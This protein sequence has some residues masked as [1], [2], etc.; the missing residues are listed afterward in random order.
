MNAQMPSP[1]IT[2]RHI[3][4]TTALRDHIETKLASISLDFPRIMDAHVILDA[5]KHRRSCEIVLHC[6]A[7][8]RFQVSHASDDMYTSIDLCVTKLERRMRKYKTRMLEHRHLFKRQAFRRNKHG[9]P[10]PAPTR[11][12]TFSGS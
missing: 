8:G 9:I 2:A 7:H 5:Q 3:E 6:E 4:L 10:A 1:N 11:A 12:G